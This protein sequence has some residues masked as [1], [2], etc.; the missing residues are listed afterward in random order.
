M[1]VLVDTNLLTRSLQP[2]SP[3]FAVATSALREL[4]RQ[5]EQLCVVPQ[6]IYEFW[7]VCTRPLGENGLALTT[8]D[9]NLEQ[10]RVLSLFT[11]LPDSPALFT[12]WQRL[13]V[14]HKVKGKSAHDARLVAA[15]IVHEMK[16]ILTFNGTD[17]SRYPGIAV[18]SP[19]SFLS[20]SN[21]P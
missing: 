19:E 6:V 21:S 11:L 13:V 14:Q 18:L 9:A 3:D 1:S 2:A 10:L 12:E 20:A 16:S 5:Q 4:N 7:T 8:D 15:M 17:F